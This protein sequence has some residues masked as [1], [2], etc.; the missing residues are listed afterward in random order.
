[1]RAPRRGDA[2]SRRGVVVNSLLAAAGNLADAPARAKSFLSPA[3]A[4][5]FK[6]QPIVRVIHPVEQPLN[7][8]GSDEVSIRGRV[9]GTLDDNGVLQPSADPTIIKYGFRGEEIDGQRGL[10]LAEA[11]SSLLLTDEA[12]DRYYDLRTIYFWNTERTVLV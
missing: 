10:F 6:P 12:L 4:A 5:T 9:V 11:P 2:D 8:P 7:N 3:M 1:P